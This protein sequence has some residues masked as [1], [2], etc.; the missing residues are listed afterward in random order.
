MR[1]AVVCAALAAL[2][3]WLGADLFSLLS[4]FVAD[5]LLGSA[6]P[7]A[8]GSGR[9]P[10]GVPYSELPHIVNADGQHLFCRYWEPEGPAK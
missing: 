2:A 5:A 8:E 1:L 4:A 3:C 6:M 9:T 7:E 10:Q